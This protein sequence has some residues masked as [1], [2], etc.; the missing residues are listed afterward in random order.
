[1]TADTIALRDGRCT[2]EVTQGK[3]KGQRCPTPAMASRTRCR[4]HEAQ[5]DPALAERVKAERQL[6][7]YRSALRGV[8]PEGTPK[9][10][11]GD[12]VAIRG[13]LEDTVQQTRTGALA[14]A[15]AT[16]VFKG[17]EVALRLAE[18]ELEAR[19]AALEVEME[20]EKR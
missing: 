5:H 13:L 9:P 11:L 4:M 8:L 10:N 19:L 15:I 17:I 2:A 14:P 18:L 3:R 16:V 20:H 12:R 7:G 1:M 6:G